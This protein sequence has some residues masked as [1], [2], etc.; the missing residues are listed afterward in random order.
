VIDS[1]SPLGFRAG[2]AVLLGRTNVGKS[3]LVNALVGRKVSIVTHRPQT[4]QHPIHGVVH[5]P[6]GQVVVVDT[7]GFFKTHKSA[8]VDSLHQRAKE[9]LRGIDVVVHVVDPARDIGEESDMVTA[10]L[11][12]VE[13][14]RILCLSKCDVLE[15]PFRDNWLALAANYAAVVEVSGFTG[16]GCEALIE[17]MLR[18]MPEGHALYPPD[19]LTNTTLDFRVAEQIREKVYQHTGEE[20]PYRTQVEVDLVEERPDTKGRPVLH[21]AAAVVTPNDRYQ[22]MLI[23]AGACKIKQIRLAAQDELRRQLGQ[24]VKL[25]LDVIVDRK[26]DF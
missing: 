13:Q 8:L 25:E 16:V 23:G 20:V 4:T 5:R 12:H 10:A 6:G 18:L 14:P 19:Q 26:M 22:R 7:P 1:S 3:T 9:A 2:L 21:V 17:E 24:K 15:R 11:A